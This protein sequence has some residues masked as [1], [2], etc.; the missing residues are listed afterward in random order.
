M[1]E[2]K[3]TLEGIRAELLTTSGMP[4][5]DDSRG[6]DREVGTKVGQSRVDPA[7]ESRRG[8]SL[9]SIKLRLSREGLGA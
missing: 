8:R 1:A 3:E 7:T 9:A 2:T 6:V 4:V 5:W